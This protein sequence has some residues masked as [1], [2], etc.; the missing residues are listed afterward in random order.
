MDFAGGAAWKACLGRQGIGVGGFGLRIA[1]ATNLRV[2]GLCFGVGMWMQE[3]LAIPLTLANPYYIPMSAHRTLTN[4]TKS[5]ALN[6][7]KRSSKACKIVNLQDSNSAN[8]ASSFEALGYR[9]RS[10]VQRSCLRL[11]WPVRE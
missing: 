9:M 5:A 6:W 1:Y 7:A 10:E 4:P 2:W 3:D 11:L 8:D